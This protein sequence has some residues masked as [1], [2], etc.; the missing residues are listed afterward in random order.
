M[1]LS[2]L[3]VFNELLKNDITS[4]SYKGHNAFLSAN[5]TMAYISLLTEEQIEDTCSKVGMAWTGLHF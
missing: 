4:Y 5:L 2:M 3:F 1:L